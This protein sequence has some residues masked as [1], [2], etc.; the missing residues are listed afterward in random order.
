MK[1]SLSYLV[2]I[3]VHVHIQTS[4]YT[5][6]HTHTHAHTHAR[7]HTHMHTGQALLYSFCLVTNSNHDNFEHV[8][9]HTIH[10]IHK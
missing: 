2:Y 9:I 8:M 4:M 5:H 7:T 6:T 3:Y 1:Y 10:Q